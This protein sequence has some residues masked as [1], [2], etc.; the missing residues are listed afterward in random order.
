[1]ESQQLNYI[2]TR[3]GGEEVQ[4]RLD[5]AR[6]TTSKTSAVTGDNKHTPQ[7]SHFF[8]ELEMF[9]NIFSFSPLSKRR[10]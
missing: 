10:L 6:M 9:R 3:L 8:C 5:M 1:M 7:F 2:P 4:E